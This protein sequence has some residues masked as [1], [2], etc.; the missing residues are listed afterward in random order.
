LVALS[1]VAS[2]FALQ[3]EDPTDTVRSSSSLTINWTSQSSD[4]VFSIEL[5]NDSFNRQFAIANNVQPSL[6]TLT[7]TLPQI[8]S[9]GGYTIQFVNISNINDIFTQTSTFSVED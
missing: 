9:G 2:A 4:P 5:I 8:P 7:L 3:V 1:L 6:N